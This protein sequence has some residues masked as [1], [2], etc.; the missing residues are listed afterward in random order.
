M[1]ELIVPN[2]MVI[3]EDNQLLAEIELYGIEEDT[4]TATMIL[5][6]DG[7]VQSEFT[8]TMAFTAASKDSTSASVA[9]AEEYDG[10]GG[11]SFGLFSL[12]SLFGLG[13]LRRTQQSK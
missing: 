13:F 6:R 9:P 7:E 4:Y 12:L 1:S 10:S 8:E 11:G 5:T 2:N 3:T